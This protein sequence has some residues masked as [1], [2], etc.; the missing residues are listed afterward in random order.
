MKKILFISDT[1]NQ[2]N[3]IPKEYLENID[4]EIETIIHCGDVSSSGSEYEII[5]FLNW[6]NN[7]PFLNKIFIPGNHDWFFERPDKKMITKLLS[8]Y[9][10][11]TY[12][13]DS[14]V[15]IEG[16][17]IWGSPV[18][19]FFG[20][21]AFNRVGEEIKKH[22]DL[23]PEDINILITHGGPTDIGL[24]NVVLEGKDVGCPYLKNRIMELSNLKIFCQGHIHE[25]YG[26]FQIDNSPLYLNASVLNRRYEMRN[27]PIIVDYDKLEII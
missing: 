22:W 13:N 19:P 18:Q 2:H 7:L 8:N 24:L 17:K 12:L 6:F 25:G 3:L 27:K 23:I 14:G 10:N 1:H 26:S 4:G 5:A 11:I 20:G 9:P 21:W 16:I 15:E